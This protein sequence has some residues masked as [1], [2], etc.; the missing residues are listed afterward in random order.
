MSLM[1]RHFLVPF[2]A[3]LLVLG[4]AVTVMSFEGP[5][6]S[7]F[8]AVAVTFAF[9]VIVGAV[10]PRH[11][12]F[13]GWWMSIPVWVA[14]LPGA[15]FTNQASLDESMGYMWGLPVLVLV[16]AYFGMFLGS[17]LNYRLKLNSPGDRSGDAAT[18]TD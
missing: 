5:A 4:A 13:A 11:I 1:I 6:M 7:F 3:G 2:I 18:A 9:A 14:F 12:K 15:F 16:F 17:R 10:M 8:V